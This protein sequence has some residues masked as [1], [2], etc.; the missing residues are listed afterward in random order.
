MKTRGGVDPRASKPGAW[1]P[2]G[3]LANLHLLKLQ[4]NTNV[5]IVIKERQFRLLSVTGII[6]TE[7][8]SMDYKCPSRT[9]DG[10]DS[11]DADEQFSIFAPA[12]I[13][14][15]QLKMQTIL[16]KALAGWRGATVLPAL[17]LAGGGNSIVMP[18]G[19]TVRLIA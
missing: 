9:D 1:L 16:G 13:Q 17:L 4:C 10:R 19:H 6:A 15:F 14:N 3:P 12:S 8:Y 7:K 5:T 18:D 11:G 2:I